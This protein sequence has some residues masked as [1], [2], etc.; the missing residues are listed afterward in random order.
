MKFQ[1]LFIFLLAFTIINLSITSFSHETKA[2]TTESENILEILSQDPNNPYIDLLDK[3]PMEI[4]EQGTVPSAKWLNENNHQLKGQF[5]A[6]GEYVKFIPQKKLTGTRG[7]GA[8]AWEVAKA[9]AMNFIPWAKV[10]KVKAV[11]K[12]FGGFAQLT[13][14]IYK[15]YTHQRNLGLSKSNAIKKAVKN[16][17]SSDKFGASKVEAVL[18]FFDLD[19]VIKECF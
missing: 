3:I 1:K 10:L 7:A 18:Q 2:A 11:A 9:A 4:A 15:S 14:L 5:I 13:R 12:S 19:S 8:C 17:V 16:V 6:D